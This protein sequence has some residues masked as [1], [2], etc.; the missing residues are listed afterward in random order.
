MIVGFGF[1]KITAEKKTSVHGKVD[2]NNNISIK[3][4]ETTD[5]SLVKKK[6]DA[7]KFIFEFMSKYEPSLGSIVFEGEIIYVDEP[8]NTKEILDYWNKEKKI[9]NEIMASILNA[10]LSKCNIQALIISQEINLPP[11][12]PMPKV[13]IN[14]QQDADK[15]YI[16]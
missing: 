6:Q 2:V 9:K 13:S 10:I 14:K 16:G 8:K 1:T 4:I 3:S 15:G 5:F 12:I 7:L 11:P